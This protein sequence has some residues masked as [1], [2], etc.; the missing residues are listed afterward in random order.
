MST[1]HSN[2]VNTALGHVIVR[3]CL[4]SC[5]SV[6]TQIPVVPYDTSLVHVSSIYISYGTYDGM[7]GMVAM[8]IEDSV[9]T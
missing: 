3:H 5:I 6:L 8:L 7:H 4:V 1:D 2:A 9:T